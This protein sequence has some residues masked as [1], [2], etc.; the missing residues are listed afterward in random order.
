M[1]A[2]PAG[3]TATTSAAVAASI[4]WPAAVARL[5]AVSAWDIHACGDHDRIGSRKDPRRVSS[6]SSERPNARITA[7]YTEARTTVTS[8]SVSR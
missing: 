8:R 3:V 7:R 6:S 1:V 4:R 2:S 5:A